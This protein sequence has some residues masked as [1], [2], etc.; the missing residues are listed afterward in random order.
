VT[1]TAAAEG[2]KQRGAAAAA[3]RAPAL[4]EGGRPGGVGERPPPKD[5][6]PQSTAP[7]PLAPRPPRPTPSRAPPPLPSTSPPTAKVG[8]L[9]ALLLRCAGGEEECATVVADCLGQLALLAPEQVCKDGGH[10]ACP[11]RP[12]GPTAAP[13][14]VRP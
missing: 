6:R 13:G 8:E 5:S 7:R 11:L 4:S 1:R 12:P 14:R 3:A 9:L 10:T 2:A